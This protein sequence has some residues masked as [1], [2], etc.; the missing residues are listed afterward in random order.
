MLNAPQLIMVF[1]FT[2]PRGARLPDVGR[3]VQEACFNSRAREARRANR[4]ID[5]K[6]VFHSRPARPPCPRIAPAALFQ[7]TRRERRDNFRRPLQA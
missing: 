1:Q 2:R 4:P 6:T 3:E 5:T 7:F